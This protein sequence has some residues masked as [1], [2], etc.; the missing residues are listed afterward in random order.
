MSVRSLTRCI[1]A[2]LFLLD[3][4]GPL[5]RERVLTQRPY[6]DRDRWT[7]LHMQ[8]YANRCPGDEILHYYGSTSPVSARILWSISMMESSPWPGPVSVI[9][10]LAVPRRF[11]YAISL[12]NHFFLLPLTVRTLGDTAITTDV[13]FSHWLTVLKEKMIIY[14]CI[15]KSK[16]SRF[17]KLFLFFNTIFM[18]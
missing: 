6:I 12:L 4:S 11:I 5:G 9:D 14:G 17:V 18:N 10:R 16:L 8:V 15:Q 7:V 13:M 2:D 1:M 3:A